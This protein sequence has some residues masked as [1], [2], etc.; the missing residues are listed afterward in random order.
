MKVRACLS[1]GLLSFLH[2]IA[3]RPSFV[4]N[5]D[6]SVT[7]TMLVNLGTVPNYQS[8]NTNFTFHVVTVAPQIFGVTILIFEN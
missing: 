8:I 5:F 2:S 4:Q 1:S 3:C 7:H 6:T